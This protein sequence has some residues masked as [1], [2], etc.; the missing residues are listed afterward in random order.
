MRI[1]QASPDYGFDGEFA[2]DQTKYALGFRSKGTVGIIPVKIWEGISDRTITGTTVTSLIPPTVSGQLAIGATFLAVRNRMVIEMQGRYTTAATL[3]NITIIFKT[4]TGNL[5]SQVI[6]LPASQTDKAWRLRG[7]CVI[8]TIGSS[9]TVQFQGEFEYDDAS[10][11]QK[12]V[13][14][15]T[16]SVNTINTTIPQTFDVTAQWTNTGKTIVTQIASLTSFN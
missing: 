8:R 2:H 15:V 4:S 5:S 11:G 1:E 9:G 12:R 3:N 16:S 13:N 14:F 7:V 6:T 10:L